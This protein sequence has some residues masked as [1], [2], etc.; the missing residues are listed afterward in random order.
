MWNYAILVY[1]SRVQLW[2]WALTLTQVEEDVEI[3]QLEKENSALQ[4]DIDSLR[5]ELLALNEKQNRRGTRPS[6]A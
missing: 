6:N 2:F 1:P 4:L 5:E 3:Q